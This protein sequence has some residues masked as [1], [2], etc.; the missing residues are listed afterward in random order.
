MWGFKFPTVISLCMAIGLVLSVSR[1]AKADQG[2]HNFDVTGT[3]PDLSFTAARARTDQTVS[4][5]D[6]RG[7]IVLLYFGYTNCPD[8]CPFTLSHVANIL[9]N[10]GSTASQIRFLFVTVDPDRDTPKI[11]AEYMQDFGPDFI[12]LRPTPDQLAALARRYRIAYSVTPASA[13]HD[14]EV[15]HSSAIYAFDKSGAARLLIPSL[16]STTPDIAGTEAD[17]KRLANESATD[18]LLA[19]VRAWFSFGS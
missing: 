4:Q 15:V 14:E 18:G 16:G 12:G 13:G 17:L 2:W 8:I 11:L 3:S 19:H 9:D 6:F 7:K 1:D 5:E 10:L